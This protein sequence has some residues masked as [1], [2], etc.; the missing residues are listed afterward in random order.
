MGMI[1]K[2]QKEEI[3][4]VDLPLRADPIEVGTPVE[5]PVE[6]PATPVPVEVGQ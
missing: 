6:V 3:R 1:G 5:T 2:P 4:W